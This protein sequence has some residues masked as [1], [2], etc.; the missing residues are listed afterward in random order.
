VQGTSSFFREPVKDPVFDGW[1]NS[2]ETTGGA[3]MMRA[4]EEEDEAM[5]GLSPTAQYT[6]N[7][8]G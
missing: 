3:G 2:M 8:A 7:S 4:R 5:L 6:D 1:L